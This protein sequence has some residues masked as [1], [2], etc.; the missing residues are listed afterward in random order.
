[1]NEKYPGKV[2]DQN[3]IAWFSNLERET[4]FLIKRASAIK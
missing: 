4:K 1:M 2:L 3:T